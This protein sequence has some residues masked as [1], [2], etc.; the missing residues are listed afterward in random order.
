MADRVSGQLCRNKQTYKL[1]ST[2]FVVVLVRNVNKSHKTF[3]FP[4]LFLSKQN[5][6]TIQR[7]KYI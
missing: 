4:V 6:L 7:R 3:S 2:V 1:S 5:N